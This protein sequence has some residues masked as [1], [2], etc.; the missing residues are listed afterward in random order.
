VTVLG[1][2]VVVGDTAGTVVTGVDED[3]LGAAAVVVSAGVATE[4]VVVAVAGVVAER[5]WVARGGWRART[6]C[7]R[8]RN[9]GAAPSTSAV[10]SGLCAPVAWTPTGPAVELAW[11][12]A[13]ASRVVDWLGVLAEQAVTIAA[14]APRAAARAYT[15]AI[16]SVRAARRRPPA[17][18][19]G[20]PDSSGAG[21]RGVTCSSLPSVT[22]TRTDAKPLSESCEAMFTSDRT[23]RRVSPAPSQSPQKSVGAPN[24]SHGSGRGS[25]DARDVPAGHADHRRGATQR[26]ARI[27]GAQRL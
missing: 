15:G 27:R 25:V 8:R 5:G 20:E 2:V 24:A 11:V 19:A 13:A 17:P 22:V 14:A 21:G 1:T 9:D 16:L 4:V 18:R 6:V 7:G 3:V 23:T 26:R 10:C 12:S